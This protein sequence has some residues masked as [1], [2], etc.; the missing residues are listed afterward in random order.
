MRKRLRSSPT[1]CRR[2]RPPVSSHGRTRGQD[3]RRRLD[4]RVSEPAHAVAGAMQMH[5]VLAGMRRRRQRT[6][7]ASA[8]P[9][10]RC[11]C[12]WAGTRRGGRNRRRLLRRRRQRGGAAARPCRR[13]RDAG[14]RAG[15]RRAWR[16]ERLRFRSLDRLVLRGRVEP[17]Q[18][19]VLGGRRGAAATARRRSSATWPRP[20]SRTRIRLVWL[21]VNRVFASQPDPV[22]LGRSPQ[23]TYRVDD[24]ARVAL[25]RA[26]STGTAAASSSATSATTAPTCASTRRRDRQ[27]APRQLHAARQRHHRPGRQRPP[28]PARPAC[29][30]RCCA[31]PRPSRRHRSTALTERRLHRATSPALTGSL[32]RSLRR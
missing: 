26:A 23:A 27:P 21:D 8:R 9:A 16:W 5:D 14:H 17:V 30:S 19:H 22:V 2:W 11:G 24:I 25:A 32:M 31:S 1:A 12:R 4:G 20:P 7:V 13:Q 15:A 28:T 3:A 10:S 18:V 29:A 6:A